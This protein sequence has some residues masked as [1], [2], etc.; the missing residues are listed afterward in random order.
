MEMIVNIKR[1]HSGGTEGRYCLMTWMQH[2]N[3]LLELYMFQGL[4]ERFDDVVVAIGSG[5]TACGLAVANQL[6]GAKLK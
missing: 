6:T 1:W 2:C 3:N 4:L 5:G